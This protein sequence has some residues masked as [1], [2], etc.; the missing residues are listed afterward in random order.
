MHVYLIEGGV[1][2]TVFEAHVTLLA[3]E[4]VR[5]EVHV[6]TQPRRDSKNTKRRKIT[7]QSTRTCKCINIT[8]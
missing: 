1:E 5:L 8:V 4:R 6:A 3:V 7:V 2:R